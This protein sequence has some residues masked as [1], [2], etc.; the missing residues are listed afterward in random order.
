M[1]K[2]SQLERLSKNALINLFWSQRRGFLGYTN[3]FTRDHQK[4]EDIFQEACLRFLA[5]KAIF[6]R[7]EA[8]AKYIYKTIRSLIIDAYRKDR[9]LVFSD[10][11][12][13]M[14]HEPEAQWQDRMV[15]GRVLK[16]LQ[17]LSPHERQLVAVHLSSDLPDLGRKS[18]FLNLPPSTYR[19]QV[20][21]AF[22]CIRKL[23]NRKLGQVEK[24]RPKRIGG[25]TNEIA[26]C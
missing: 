4:I 10:C 8:A 21:R 20:Q 25:K 14:I 16:A 7:R 5:S 18:R 22:R 1:E 6:Y 11:L 17:S 24:S 19:Y 13:E 2:E 9:K 23:M 3:R 26:E 15:V 12:P